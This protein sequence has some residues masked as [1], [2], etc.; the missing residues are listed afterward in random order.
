[1]VSRAGAS[2]RC[3]H[4]GGRRVVGRR[5]G[6]LFH[7]GERDLIDRSSPAGRWIRIAGGGLVLGLIGVV[8]G[9]LLFPEPQ[10][11]LLLRDLPGEYAKAGPALTARL[12]ARF[13]KGSDEA[14][15]IR[16]LAAQGFTVTPLSHSADWKRESVPC[17]EIARIWWQ[18]KGGKLVAIEGL[19]NAICP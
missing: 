1:M 18:A 11:P 14:L 19:R 13:P 6:G 7:F 5:P 9:N 8:A 17:I 3:D 4:V 10:A 12:R 15:L 16:E 2:G